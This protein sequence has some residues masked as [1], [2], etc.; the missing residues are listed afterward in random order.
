MVKI[1][2]VPLLMLNVPPAPWVTVK[3][4]ATV[5]PVEVYVP[6][7]SVPPETEP[8]ENVPPESVPPESVAPLIVPK[9]ESVGLPEPVMLPVKV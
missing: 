7:E 6:P 3:P 4:P 8:P 1:L 9:P 5:A 2:L